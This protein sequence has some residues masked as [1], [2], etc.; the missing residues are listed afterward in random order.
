MRLS[1]RACAV[2]ALLGASACADQNAPTTL[3]PDPPAA[4]LPLGVYEIAVTGIGTEQ[5]YSSVRPADPLGGTGPSRSLAVA[6]SGI[7]F[8]QVSSSSFTEGARGSGGQRHVT[9]TYRVRNGTGAALNNVTVLMV[10]RSGTIAGT[11]VSTLRRFDGTAANP[12]IGPSVVPTGAVSL[13]SDLVSMRADYPDVLQVLSEAEVAAITPPAGVTEVFPYGYMVRSADPSATHRTLPASPGPNQYDGVLTVSFRVPLQASAAE[14]VFSFFFQVMPVQ[15][16]ETRLT[17]SMEEGQDTASVRRLR[18]RAAALGATTVT[19]LNGSPAAGADVADYP[20]QRQLCAVRTAGSAA[21]P[22]TYINAPAAYTRLVLLR[23]SES[24]SACAADFR[25]GTAPLPT[26][27]APYS[28][29]VR[30]MDRYGNV[31]TTAV[32]TVALTQTSGPSATLGAGGALVNGVRTIPVTYHANGTSLLTAAGRRMRGQRTIEVATAATVVVNTGNNQAAMAGQAVPVAPSVLVRDLG[33]NPLAGVPVTFAVAG[34]GGYVTGAT[35]T[36]NGSGIA[37]VGSWVLGTPAT[38]NGLSATAAGATGSV[39]FT[40]SGC[41][42]GGGTGYRMTLCY[43]TAMTASQR[44]AF[45]SAAAR[46]QRVVSADLPDIP[47]SIAAAACGTGT[48]SL[49]MSVDDLLIFAAVESM[50]GPGGTLGSAGPCYIRGAGGGSLPF[51][52]SMRFDAA[53]MAGLESSGNLNSVILHEMGHVLGIGTM[54]SYFGLTTNPSSVAGP[55]LDTYYNGGNGIG[56]FNSIG[57]STYTGGQKVPVENTGGS[58]TINAHWRKSVLQ[59]ELMTG[60]LTPGAIPLSLLTVRSLADMGYTVDTS[61]A[62]SFFLTLSL[63][64]DPHGRAPVPIHGAD[65][66]PLPLYRLGTNG[67]PTRLR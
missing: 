4:P 15:D 28:L 3:P 56:G 35:A 61:G 55:P 25:T 36:T 7:A 13:Q 57:G 64:A 41:A 48:P 45:E 46:W 21:L 19:V 49:D 17:E 44:T 33:G 37:T 16:T 63:Q 20:G 31:V 51:I 18:E 11:P 58:G 40:A 8:E 32:D 22:L 27:N 62:D 67:K 42:G 30:A 47:L 10:S 52:G 39:A 53:D 60:W 24:G 23:P 54:W 34:G 59:N 6:G 26:L 1:I 43:R 38:V 12:A 29:T 65:E 5:L 2:L 66:P 14:D 50:D 9:F